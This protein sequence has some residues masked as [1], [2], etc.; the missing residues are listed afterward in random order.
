VE[1]GRIPSMGESVVDK[2]F[3]VDIDLTAIDKL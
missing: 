3:P 2:P 1:G